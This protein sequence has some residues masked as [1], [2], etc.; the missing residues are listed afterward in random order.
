MHQTFSSPSWVFE[1]QFLPKPEIGKFDGDP[2]KYRS[3]RN[4]F[5]TH[6]KSKFR[7]PKILLCLLLQHCEA[8]VKNQIEH[9]SN[10]GIDDYGLALDRLEREYGH[11]WVIADACERR[12]R[13]FVNVKSSDLENLRMF[14]D[15]L[16]KTKVLLKDIQC[17][18][19]LNSLESIT[20]LVNKLPY[21][22]KRA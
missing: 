11:P 1:D 9:F 12:L 20:T 7:D 16:E 5:E 8:K 10:K 3:F 22:M 17:Y 6:I 19:S 4:N 2:L 15:L 21:D 14:A 13:K 18:G